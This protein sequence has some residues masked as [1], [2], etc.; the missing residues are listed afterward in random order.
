M[1]GNYALVLLRSRL[2][3]LIRYIS[4]P[5]EKSCCGGV[6]LQTR[7]DLGKTLDYDPWTR[8]PGALRRK[9]LILN[10]VR[11]RCLLPFWFKCTKKQDEDVV[12]VRKRVQGR[13]GSE[14]EDE[15]VRS[16]SQAR[17]VSRTAELAKYGAGWAVV[18]GTG[19]GGKRQPMRQLTETQSWGWLVLVRFDLSVVPSLIQ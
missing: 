10:S 19:G 18:F 17:A 4:K 12:K 7:A 6:G 9:C 5:K 11:A 14:R 2:Q 1:P 13:R 15:N 16:P 3:G 8:Y